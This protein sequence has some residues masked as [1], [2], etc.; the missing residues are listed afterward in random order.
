MARFNPA[1]L[2]S[3]SA[4]GEFVG[5]LGSKKSDKKTSTKLPTIDSAAAQQVDASRREKEMIEKQLKLIET[6]RLE[7]MHQNRKGSIGVGGT[8]AISHNQWDQLISEYNIPFG[9]KPS[10]SMGLQKIIAAERSH[11]HLELSSEES[12]AAESDDLDENESVM[13]AGTNQIRKAL[14]LDN[15]ANNTV[16]NLDNENGTENSSRLYPSL[17][18]L[19]LKSR[20]ADRFYSNNLKANYGDRGSQELAM[21]YGILSQ[22][23]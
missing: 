12:E 14:V 13:G 4:N 9:D 3:L 5:P 6:R 8:N 17:N 19:K 10:G 16:T 2:N 22:V 21:N 11:I 18:G 20:E 7:L 23:F 1:N 15:E